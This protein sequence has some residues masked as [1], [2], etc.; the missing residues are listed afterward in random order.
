MMVKKKLSRTILYA[1]LLILFIA[2]CQTPPRPSPTPRLSATDRV[3]PSSTQH[4]IVTAMLARMTGKLVEIDGCIRVKDMEAGEGYALVW[5]PDHKM[6]VEDGTVQVV[7]GLVSGDL[8]EVTLKIGEDV[9]LGGGEVKELDEQLKGTIPAH[10]P[11][12]SWVVGIRIYPAT[13]K[14]PD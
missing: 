12:P 10:C 4:V 9:I 1:I 3:P 8:K 11:G 6:T 13:T 14:T 5:P 2:S 7:S